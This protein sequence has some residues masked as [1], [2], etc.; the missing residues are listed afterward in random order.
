MMETI[1]AVCLVLFALTCLVG[2]VW[3]LVSMIND[4]DVGMIFL[5]ALTVLA[6]FGIMAAAISSVQQENS[7]PCVAWGSTTTTYMMVGKTM[8]P[9]TNTPCIRRQ[10][11]VEK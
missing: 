10:N 8:M 5:A 3:F 4:G 11:E 7:K 2:S 1:A 9:V 6:V